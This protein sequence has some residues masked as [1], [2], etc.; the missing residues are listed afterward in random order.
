[1]IKTKV[2][3]SGIRLIVEDKK[4]LEGVS[5]RMFFN[6]GS[7]NET[8]EIFG[9]SHLIEHMLFKGTQKRNA[10]QIA[11]DL[12]KIGAQVNAYTSKDSTCYYT[13]STIDALET[14]VEVL[15]D[16]FF[17]STFDEKELS[18]EK[19]VVIE[20][21]K[22]YKDQPSDVVDTL[23]YE[24]FF[25][26]T[27]LAHDVIGN[28][29]SVNSITREQILNYINSYYTP[30]NL[31]ICFVGHVDFEKALYFTEKYIESNFKI[32]RLPEFKPNDKFFTPIK[33]QAKK[34]MKTNQSHVIISYPI[35]NFYSDTPYYSLLNSCLASGM[36]SRLFQ[37]IREKLGLVYAIFCGINRHE[38]GGMFYIQ[39]AT[40]T[41]N[42]PLALSTIREE[43]N[44][45]CREGFSKEEINSA[46]TAIISNIKLSCDN[47][48]RCASV[49]I[50]NLLYKNK[51]LTKQERIKLIKK[52]TLKELNNFSKN[53]FET[54]NYTIS[55]VGENTKID[56]LKN[57][58]L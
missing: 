44:K 40:S 37:I 32:K 23:N 18:R 35:Q 57:F 55:M 5:F 11:Y 42:V 54:E 25:K 39:F 6:T 30:N 12:E 10:Y 27:T 46:K 33:S 34:S 31:I 50:S 13:Y 41:K 4:N 8:P 9:I 19:K 56:L 28:E 26:D 52:A 53:L 7:V 20:E 1:M 24:L 58:E 29:K 45:L 2:L 38:I 21:M 43:L 49:N 16:M 36:S 15:S 22:M 14:C 48:Q 51:I 3:N 47:I 17:N